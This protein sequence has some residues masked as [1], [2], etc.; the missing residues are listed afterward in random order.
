MVACV[1]CC[2]LNRWWGI[3]IYSNIWIFELGEK[4][5]PASN[6][7]SAIDDCCVPPKFSMIFLSAVTVWITAIPYC[8][9]ASPPH[10]L[11]SRFPCIGD[12]NL[13]NCGVTL[14]CHHH[15]LLWWWWN[16]REKNR[17]ALKGCL[18][19]WERGRWATACNSFMHRV[20]MPSWVWG[21]NL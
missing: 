15:Q 16:D 21:R 8:Q 3:Q 14:S 13:N 20:L 4:R 2:H 5:N 11:L 17:S 10:Q 7:N 9:S 1:V 12:P 19:C 6:D 18:C